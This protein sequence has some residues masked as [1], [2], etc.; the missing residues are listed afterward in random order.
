M[1]VQTDIHAELER[2]KRLINKGSNRASQTFTAV[3]DDIATQTGF[4]NPNY[5][6]K[7]PDIEVDREKE[8][9]KGVIIVKPI[10]NSVDTTLTIES[11]D[12]DHTSVKPKL[13]PLF[14]RASNSSTVET[15]R[16]ELEGRNEFRKLSPIVRNKNGN[17][18]IDFMNRPQSSPTFK[19]RVKVCRVIN[20]CQPWS[21]KSF[22]GYA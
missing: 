6:M 8:L 20:Y 21:H 12:S 7:D 18:H 2:R 11:V 15:V 14:G 13:S 16:I 17:Q 1:R 3:S 22:I 5:N 4:E 10:T 19:K 9:E